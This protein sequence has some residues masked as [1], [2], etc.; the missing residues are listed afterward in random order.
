[1]F[2]DNGGG[3][4]NYPYLNQYFQ[5]AWEYNADGSYK[6]RPATDYEKEVL[7]YADQVPVYNS[8]NIPTT[9]WTD[10]VTRTAITHNHQISCQLVLKNLICTFHWLIWIKSLR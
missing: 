6:M 8:A 10:Y 1:M 3:V 2:S 4:S 9:P 7:G 5:K